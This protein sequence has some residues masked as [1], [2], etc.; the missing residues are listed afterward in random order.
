[1]SEPPVKVLDY[2]H[3]EGTR[4]PLGRLVM[5]SGIAAIPD[6][7]VLSLFVRHSQGDWGQL[8]NEDVAEN[9][10]ALSHGFRLLSSYELTHPNGDP[11]KVWVI[12]EADRSATTMLLPEEY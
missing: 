10:L 12:T 1:M 11:L 5:T 2:L 7:P 6:L 9:E 8:D 3:S 4:F